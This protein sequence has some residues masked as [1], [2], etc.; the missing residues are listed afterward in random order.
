MME[1]T[2]RG[3]RFAMGASGSSAWDPTAGIPL[4]RS[5]QLY[6]TSLVASAE[7]NK[8]HFPSPPRPASRLLPKEAGAAK[9][10]GVT[11]PSVA[12]PEIAGFSERS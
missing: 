11:N 8:Y 4:L 10:L 2:G 12:E 6:L 1:N 7:T 9:E 5:Q 3:C